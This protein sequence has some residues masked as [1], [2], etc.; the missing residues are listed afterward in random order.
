VTGLTVH[1]PT[2][3][4]SRLILRAPRMADYVHMMDFMETGRSQFVGGPKDRRDAM[5]GFGHIAGLWV[6]RG[7]SLFIGVAKGDPDTPIGAFGPY[8]PLDWSELEFGWSIWNPENEGKGYVTE[9]LR[10]LIPWSWDRAGTSTAVSFIDAD[11]TRSAR[12]AQ[13]L[14]AVPDT[15]ATEAAN[16]P[17]NP[18]HT[19]E[20]PKVRVWRHNRGRQT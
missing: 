4:T 5:R 14:G 19:P 2:L 10:A 6:T 12:V 3:E 15:A 11:N 17:G 18:F 1:I 7:Y 16:Q 20:G 13:A 9:A 8:Y